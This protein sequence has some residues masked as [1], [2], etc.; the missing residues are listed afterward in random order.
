MGELYGVCRTQPRCETGVDALQ[1]RHPDFDGRDTIIAVLDTGV[2]PA[3]DGLQVTSTGK[4]K[5][6]ELMD[7]TGAGDVDTST[8]VTAQDGVIIGLS[9]RK[10]KI[11]D[12]WTNPSGKY[13]I[14]LKNIFE[15]YSKG[16]RDR[17]KKVRKERQW[18][19]SQ[20]EFL[21][22]AQKELAAHE[23]RLGK[24]EPEKLEERLEREELAARVAALKE[25]EKDYDDTGPVA[26]VVAFYDGNT[27]KACLDASFRGRLVKSELLGGFR[28]TGQ[29]AKLCEDDLLTYSVNIH[30]GGSLVEIVTT[31]GSHGT[32]VA[33]MAA[34]YHPEAK[35]KNGIAPGA[36]I[37]GLCIGD[38]RLGTMEVGSALCRALNR[39]IELGVDVVNLS[40]GEATHVPNVG[41]VIAAIEEAVWKRG[42]MFVCSAGNNG[43]A[44]S[45]GGAPGSTTTASFG[46]GAYLSP[47]M[48]EG[49]YSL[50][51]HGLP[52]QLYPWSSRG[53]TADGALG[54]SVC[55]PGGAITGVPK[56]TLQGAQLMNG[57]SMSSPH[58]AGCCAVLFS[59]L[60]Q[61]AIPASPLVLRTA[62]ENTASRPP[63][64]D[65]F[66]AGHGLLHVPSAWAWLEK[67]AAW[68]S[69]G[70]TH[71]K[72]TVNDKDRGIYLRE[73]SDVNRPRDMIVTIEPVFREDFDNEAKRAFHASLSVRVVD[74][75]G[76]AVGWVKAPSS[77]ELMNQ[78]RAFV[79]AVDPTQLPVGGVSYA[80]LECVDRKNEA[81]GPMVVVPI[82][83]VR[84][85]AVEA[86]EADKWEQVWEELTFAPGKDAMR[87]FFFAAP[88]A[89][90]Y[91]GN[92]IFSSPLLTSLTARTV[93][94]FLALPWNYICVSVIMRPFE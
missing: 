29:T 38:A 15:L 53:P 83:V 13:H 25:L 2:D 4:R 45:T 71:F 1:S 41:R 81:A 16:L 42:I 39:C 86:G 79:V 9:G 68:L 90:N 51:E 62:L 36:Q 47:E 94:I 77:L 7:C 74:E 26:D 66:S 54:T 22:G 91:A 80:Q 34:A 12:G 17:L 35:E 69:L 57:T 43:P 8:V 89:A 65:V 19:A 33:C 56:W 82:T 58:V 21:V 14:G 3:A 67:H 23:D 49:L 88:S 60:K 40:Y 24:G 87:R 10:L 92:F 72:V 76:S 85:A 46:I 5:V 55:G 27:W 70:L 18:D 93:F 52:S 50:R 64:T 48:M 20:R 61:R 75:S 84:P 73:L 28:E 11:P 37:V 6:I 78:A 32:H 63:L 31:P 59:A 30:G 44:L